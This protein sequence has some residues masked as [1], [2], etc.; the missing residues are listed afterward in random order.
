MTKGDQAAIFDSESSSDSDHM[1]GSDD[2]NADAPLKETE[3]L[4]SH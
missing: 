2:E 1:L 4:T 3:S